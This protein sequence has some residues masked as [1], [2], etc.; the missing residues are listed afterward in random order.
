MAEIK[1][2]GAR[3]SYLERGR[4]SPVVFS[5]GYLWSGRM[6]DAQVA[7]LESRFRCIAFDHRG[8][9]H[10]E[11]TES[12][13][14][15]DELA[16][17]AAALIKSLGAAPC[18]YVG[19]SMGGFVGMRLAARRPELIRSLSLL[20][21]SASPESLFNVLRYRML[22]VVAQ[23]AGVKPV[24]GMAMRSMF[25]RK[26]LT[27]P[28]RSALRAEQRR[29]LMGNSLQGMLRTLRGIIERPTVEGELSSIRCPTLVIVGEQDVAT[30]PAK[31]ERIHALIPGSRLVVIPGAGHTSTVEEPEAVNAALVPFLDRCEASTPGAPRAAAAVSR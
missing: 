9:G 5:H 21:T 19:L 2:R 7:A 3:L 27:D 31:A 6:F 25:G 28:S 11:V 1:I 8:Q 22:G 12:G 30:V 13:Y 18:H 29:L 20:E 17:D 26:F 15:M 4:G 16:E 14:H 10:S 23:V 24:A